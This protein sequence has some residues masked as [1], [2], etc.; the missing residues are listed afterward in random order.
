MAGIL[1]EFRSLVTK[2]KPWGLTLIVTGFGPGEIRNKQRNWPGCLLTWPLNFIK[3]YW[4]A[5]ADI[6]RPRRSCTKIHTGFSGPATGHR[7]LKFVAEF[8]ALMD[9]LLDE[10]TDR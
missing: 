1:P 7:Y 4:H 2:T 5:I 8:N 10:D 6:H 9:E 3:E